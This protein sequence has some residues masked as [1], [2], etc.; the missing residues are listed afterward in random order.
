MLRG[1]SMYF[2]WKGVNLAEE[3]IFDSRGSIRKFGEI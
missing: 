2:Y 3:E 1:C